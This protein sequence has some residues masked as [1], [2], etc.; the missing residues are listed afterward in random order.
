MRRR[1][2][3]RRAV[4]QGDPARDRRQPAAP[5]HGL[6][7]PVPDPPLGPGHADRGD[8]GGA[9][10]RRQGRQG[11]L[12]RR[13]VDVRLA[14]RQ[15]AARGRPRT[16]GRAS[17][18]CSPTTTCSTARRSARCC[19]CAA[20]R[21]SGVIPWSPLAPRP[22]DPRPGTTHTRALADRRFG[23]T[24]YR[25]HRGRPTARRRGGG[26]GRRGA[27]RA[28]RAGGAG[29]AAGASRASPRRSSARP[30]RRTWTM[31]S[32]RWTLTLQPDEVAALEAP[33]LPHAVVGF[34]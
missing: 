10:R 34:E 5:G 23:K 32:R 18:P 4:A 14:V 9:A 33:Y 16:A 1:P 25:A 19:R 20:T 11:A 29:L 27:R 12:H 15:G 22:A 2:E 6:R 31:P 13:V 3:R 26:R 21:A 30:S 24:L 7:R 8:D 17:S 28:A